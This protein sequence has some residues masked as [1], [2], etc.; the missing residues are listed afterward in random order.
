[1]RKNRPGSRPYEYF[2]QNKGKYWI[3]DDALL[4]MNVNENSKIVELWLTRAEKEDAAMPESLKP[5]YQKYKEQKYLVTVFLSG[6]E[7]L[8]PQTRDLLLYNRRRQAEKEVRQQKAE[9]PVILCEMRWGRQSAAPLCMF[10]LQFCSP[11]C[12]DVIYIER[13]NQNHIV[14]RRI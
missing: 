8:Y 11:H 3:G 13:I 12:T 4:Q 7:E 5:I 1:M 2:P 9:Q 14:E 10:C 6:E